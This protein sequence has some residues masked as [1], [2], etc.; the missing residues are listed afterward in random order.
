M[1][2]ITLTPKYEEDSLQASF[3]K[4]K[5]DDKLIDYKECKSEKWKSIEV[6]DRIRYFVNNEFRSGGRVKRNAYPDYIVLANDIKNVSWCVQLKN[7]TLR[8]YVK[9]IK[10]IM[11]ETDEMKKIYK[12]LKSGKIKITKT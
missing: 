5:I 12:D 9:S 6:N 10:R 1:K 11:K 4:S 7:P 8:L 3:S 2:K